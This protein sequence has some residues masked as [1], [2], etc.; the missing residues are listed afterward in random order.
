MKTIRIQSRVAWFV[1]AIVILL[2]ISPA[3]AGGP[4]NPRPAMTQGS[5]SPFWPAPATEKAA[6]KSHRPV[7]VTFTKWGIQGSTTPYSLFAG[8][9]GG[10]IV[11]TY[12]GEVLHRVMTQP[13]AGHNRI[14]W[15]EAM[16]EVQAGDQS[17]TALIRGGTNTVTGAAL[18]D[19]VIL[20]GWRTGARV[21]VEFQ[22]I[23]PPSA[24][25]SGCAGAPEGK[26]CFQGTI[27]ILPGPGE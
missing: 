17:F 27:R 5:Q 15:L 24:T 22:T 19:G 18:L 9:T 4:L 3:L 20:A 7:E 21:H 13:Q 14:A 16:Y 1:S 23:P 2:R 6:D 12:V 26:T 11:G 10:D 25:E 8:F